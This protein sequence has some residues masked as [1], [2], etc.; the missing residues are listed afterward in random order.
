MESTGTLAPILYVY[1]ASPAWIII[2][3]SFNAFSCLLKFR[4]FWS[5]KREKCVYAHSEPLEI[6]NEIENDLKFL[7]NHT[8]ALILSMHQHIAAIATVW[9]CFGFF[10]TLIA[11]P[12]NNKFLVRVGA[13]VLS[14]VQHITFLC[15]SS[16]CVRVYVLFI[17]NQ[18]NHTIWLQWFSVDLFLYHCCWPM[19]VAKKCLIVDTQWSDCEGG[20]I[21]AHAQTHKRICYW[22]IILLL[23]CH[24]SWIKT[25]WNLTQWQKY[26]TNGCPWKEG[27]W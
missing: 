20:K 19:S 7:E 26:N 10:C 1:A 13:N 8:R 22:H 3:I 17:A 4:C 12:S 15:L 18:H 14:S 21:L 5:E 27:E 11:Q 25:V 16:L 6:P 24:A 2:K 23:L 9:R